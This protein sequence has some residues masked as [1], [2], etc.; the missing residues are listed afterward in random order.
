MTEL[1]YRG[2][3]DSQPGDFDERITV[4]AG[5]SSPIEWVRSRR[6]ERGLRREEAAHSRLYRRIGNL[7]GHLGD[8]WHVL[9]LRELSGEEHDSFLAVG[10]G[11]VFAVTVKDHGRSRVSFAGDVVQIDG[12]RP[13]YV[14]EARREARAAAEALSRSAGVSIPVMPVLAFAGSG[15]ISFYGVPKGC[16]VTA[17][18]E[19]PRILNA[20]GTRLAVETV[21]KVFALAAHPA[22]WFTA[23]Y[24]GLAEDYRWY[25]DG[26]HVGTDKRG[27]AE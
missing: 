14:E 8:E 9:D 18:H 24:G 21:D 20:R 26:E 2:G 22:T 1:L 19:L 25:P 17:Y 6:A 5:R 4:D 11:G 12:K 15:K 27:Y 3:Q 7:I 16:L 23:D 10:P 13:K